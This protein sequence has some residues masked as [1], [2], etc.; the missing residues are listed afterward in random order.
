M[1]NLKHKVMTPKQIHTVI[2]KLQRQVNT[3]AKFTNMDGTID[4][5]TN[6]KE[7][8]YAAFEKIQNE[9]IGKVTIP[10]CSVRM[11]LFF[12]WIH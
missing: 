7:A 6:I 9:I 1:D 2:R 11:R 4:L 3:I 8:D 5:T 12:I 10:S